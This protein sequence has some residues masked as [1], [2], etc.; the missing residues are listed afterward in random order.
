MAQ[1]QSMLTLAQL[2]LLEGVVPLMLT[3]AQLPLTL[4]P[5]CMASWVPGMSLMPHLVPQEALMPA[6]L[7]FAQLPLL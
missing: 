5:F 7:T 2:F 6:T 1:P 4:M 3:F